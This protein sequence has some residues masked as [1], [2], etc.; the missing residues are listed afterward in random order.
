MQT[1]VNLVSAGMG[2]AYRPVPD[3]A[4]HCQ[5]SLV[6]REPAP[7]VVQRFDAVVQQLAGLPAPAQ[8]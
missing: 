5:T 2:V 3:A 4:L 7:P 6:W 1:I 8:R